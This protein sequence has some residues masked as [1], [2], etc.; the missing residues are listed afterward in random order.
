MILSRLYELAVREKLLADP[1]FEM[2]P[3]PLRVVVGEGGEFRG[4]IED[5]P[6]VE[7]PPKKEGGEVK[8]KRGAGTEI[9]ITRPHGAP[10]AQGFAR[11]FADTVPRVLPYNVD[12]KNAAKEARSRETFWKQIDQAAD[13]TDDPALRAVQKFGQA[14]ATD[15]ALIAQVEE[16]VKAQAPVVTDR[17]T[18][19][20]QSERGK[21]ILERPA[22][23][24]WYA[25][26]FEQYTASR[27]EDGPTGLCSITGKVGP[28]RKTHPSLSGIP[29][30]LPTGVSFVSFD[31]AAFESYGLDKGANAGIG[32]DAADG[33]AR[34]FEWLQEKKACHVRVGATLFLFWTREPVATDFM[35]VFEAPDPAQ[36]RK[37]LDDVNKG[38]HGDTMDADTDF[39]MLAVSGNSARAVVRDYLERPLAGVRASLAKWFGDL[40]IADTSKDYQGQPNAAFPLWLLAVQTALDSDRVAPDTYSRLLHAALTDAPVPDS[41]L[42]ACI[43]RLRAEGSE[44]F[45]TSRMAL[46]KLCLNRTHF[47]GDAAMNETLN[48]DEKHAAYLYGRLLHVFEE[49]QYAALGDVNANVVDKFYGTFS[50]A[51]ALV[52]SR[53]YDGAQNHMRKLKRE[54]PGAFTNL[55]RRL[56]EITGLLPAA[57][58][59]GT[60]SLADQGRFALGY[61]HQKAKTNASR[62]EAKAAKAKREDDAEADE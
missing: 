44:G 10:A 34:G 58:P 40:R 30:G 41:V 60:L 23:R 19:E 43:G 2:L 12:P 25:K 57:P 17:V 3:V 18:F 8:F 11:L 29:G 32:Y 55:D 33:Y 48:E 61:Y 14:L 16:A 42:S 24:A 62:A 38:R 1:A 52:F 39:Y 9:S 20:L 45:K 31:K 49:I 28:L 15:K 54:K 46:I 13:E 47:T 26:F 4:I 56:T 7:I 6:Q 21:T 50:A 22:V 37:L 5:R 59:Q 36:I 35:A 27:Q 53:L 51:P